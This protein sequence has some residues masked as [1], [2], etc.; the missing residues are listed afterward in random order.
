MSANG[1]QMDD[2]E[3]ARAALQRLGVADQVV[4]IEPPV[5]GISGATTVHVTL[6]TAQ[7]VLKLLPA[8]FDANG[9]LR[10]EREL[11][12]YREMAPR[13]TIGVPVLLAADADID[14]GGALLL[15]AY[16]PPRELAA[17]SEPD[18]EAVVASLATVHAAYW[19]QTDLQARHP[20]LGSAPASATVAA[21]AHGEEMWHIQAA[22]A[23]LQGAITPATLAALPDWFAVLQR[24]EA[25][26]A[27]CPL[28]LVHGDCHLG[29]VLWSDD[30][31]P[32]LADWAQAGVGL[33]PGDMSFLLQRACGP[34]DDAAFARW[35]ARYAA[36]LGEVAPGQPDPAWT[37]RVMD[38]Y[39]LRLRLL[40]WPHYF[41]WMPREAVVHQ[42]VRLALV[43]ER[44]A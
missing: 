43:V 27:D 8:E 31:A 15:R 10:A 7:A 21:Y 32:V 22:H 18:L 23:P 37:L 28:T 19:G 3:R 1:L 38:A 41:D 20:W 39:E 30:G 4:A 24:A 13:L 34:A 33:G 5:G 40:V 26:L 2:L 6:R 16:G 44:L 12:F 9:R 14:S 35:A 42:A 17:L 25:R 36:R 29:N 11:R